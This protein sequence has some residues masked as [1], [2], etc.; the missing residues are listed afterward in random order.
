MNFPLHYLA[1]KPAPITFDAP[2]PDAPCAGRFHLNLRP[3]GICSTCTRPR[4][5]GIEPAA[6]LRQGVAQCMNFWAGEN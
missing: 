5:D 4:A 1:G 2:A 6:V 3:Y